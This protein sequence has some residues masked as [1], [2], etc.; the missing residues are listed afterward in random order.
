LSKLAERTTG[1]ST[2]VSSRTLSIMFIDVV[3]FSLIAENSRAQDVFVDLKASLSKMREIIRA[4]GG[5]V[6]K[7]LGDGLLC[8]FGASEGVATGGPGCAERALR[9]AVALQR[10]TLHECME[11]VRVGRPLSPI[12]IGI[13]T[14]PVYVG[15]LGEPGREEVTVIGHG[16]NYAKRIEDA[17]DVFM[18]LLSESTRDALGPEV[19]SRTP[20]LSRGI[21]IKHHDKLFDVFEYNPFLEAEEDLNLALKA[22]QEFRG[23]FRQVPRLPLIEAPPISVVCDFGPCRILDISPGGI[24]IALGKYLARGVHLQVSISPEK[25]DRRAQYMHLIGLT[26][27]I[28]EVKWGRPMGGGSGLFAHGIQLWNLNDEQQELVFSLLKK[29]ALSPPS[30]TEK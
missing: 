30:E 23:T 12:R 9:C 1:S 29:Y 3:G 10:Q 7:V 6:D 27:L 16:V 20:L 24:G 21:N 2:E 11:S 15:D 19:L 26:S 14:A 8:Y 17:C 5:T 18:I 22:Y 4:H 25:N 13:N 28:G